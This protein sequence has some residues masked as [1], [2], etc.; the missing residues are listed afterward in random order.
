MKILPRDS[1]A[2]KKTSRQEEPA[3]QR[4]RRFEITVEREMVCVLVRARQRGEPPI[5]GFFRG[6]S[7]EVKG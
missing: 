4:P 2:M 5:Q 3:R 6:P 1:S 7:H